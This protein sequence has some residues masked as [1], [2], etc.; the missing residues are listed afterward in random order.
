MSNHPKFEALAEV[1]KRG[2]LAPET[3]HCNR[4]EDHDRC[5]SLRQPLLNITETDALKTR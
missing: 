1:A 4:P 2:L 5:A 3:W